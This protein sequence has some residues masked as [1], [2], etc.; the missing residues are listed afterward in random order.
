MVMIR[1]T[2]IALSV[3]TLI[4]FGGAA[5]LGQSDA[6]E[7]PES[8]RG[9]AVVVTGTS[10]LIGEEEAGIITFDDP[11]VRM[12]DSVLLTIEESSDPR[13]SGRA[14]ITVNYDAYPDEAG[15]VGATQVRFGEMR[16][17]ND[18]GEW[19]GHFAGSMTSF[20]F[21]QTYWLEGEGGYEGLSY[22]VTAGGNG[23]VWRS[24]GLIYPGETP[25]MGK[26]PSLP[27]VGP[28]EVGPTASVPG[29]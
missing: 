9:A 28:G 23:N 11:I 1:S 16:L 3:S 4:A 19:N 29:T 15:L 13:V 27:A 18:D 7:P 21:M 6:P 8:A 22:V 12:R 17:V 20:G 24:Q 2:G 14:K 10:T 26:G 5:A 25:P